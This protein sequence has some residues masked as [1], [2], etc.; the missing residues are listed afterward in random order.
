[1]IEAYAQQEIHGERTFR[2]G[3]GGGGGLLV[4]KRR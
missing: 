3:G 2:G 1:M 4:K